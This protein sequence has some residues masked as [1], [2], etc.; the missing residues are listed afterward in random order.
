MGFR[1]FELVQKVG[2]IRFNLRFLSRPNKRR[3][4]INNSFLAII[5]SSG[6]LGRVL[7]PECLRIEQRF[8]FGWLDFEH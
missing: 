4:A 2:V 5:I 1:F 8:L 3:E 7:L 6:S